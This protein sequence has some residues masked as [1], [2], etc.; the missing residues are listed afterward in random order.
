MATQARASQE[1]SVLMSCVDQAR[2]ACDH[3]T[4]V[5]QS[6][7]VDWLLD[8][9]NSAHRTAVREVVAEALADVSQ[10]RLVRADQFR[11]VLHEI[12]LALAVDSIFDRFDLV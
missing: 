1:A 6:R 4:F 12:E 10:L 9:F 5:S 2:S 3:D 7:C 11:S 8:C